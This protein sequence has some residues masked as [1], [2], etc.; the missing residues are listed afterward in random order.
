MRLADFILQE[1]ETIVEQWEMF[2]AAQL[3]AAHIMKAVALRDHAPQILQAVVQ[4]LRTLQSR[5][6]QTQKSLG[7]APVLIDA[8]ETAAQT[9]AVLRAQSGFDINQLAAEYRALRASVLRLWTDTKQAPDEWYF[10]DIIRFNEAID[11]ALA[12]SVSFFSAKVDESRNLLLGMLGHDMRSPLQTIQMT[13]NYLAALNAG[14]PVS[15]AASRLINSGARIKSL[16]ADL[17]DFNRSN[18]GLGIHVHPIK[19]DVATLFLDELEQ[20]RAAHPG[21]EVILKVEGN[22]VGVWDGLRLQQLLTNL[23]SNALKYG[24]SDTPVIVLVIGDEA[25]LRI[26]VKNRGKVIEHAT[27]ARL[28]EPLIRGPEQEGVYDPSGSLGLGLFIAR[29][30]A[31]AHGGNIEAKSNSSETVFEVYLPCQHSQIN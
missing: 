15:I 23:V 30:I 27:L 6:A 29:E 12:E 2:A 4:D 8:P 18:L 16:L 20:L 19:T 1:L 3:P 25:H 10:D 26:E 31:K 24:Q 22:S 21:R 5:E 7:R 17:L 11:Q 28:F 14:A 13:A 9:H